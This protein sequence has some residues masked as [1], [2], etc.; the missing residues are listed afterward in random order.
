MRGVD[1]RAGGRCQLDGE[2]FLALQHV[3]IGDRHQN[4]LAGFARG[5]R[6]HLVHGGVVAARQGDAFD[7]LDRDA[8]GDGGRMV[9]RDR[10][11]GVADGLVDGCRA[12]DRHERDILDGAGAVHGGR[13]G[14]CL[15]IEEDGFAGFRIRVRQRRHPHDERVGA[16][17]DG[18]LAVRDRGEGLAAVEGDFQRA[19]VRAHGTGAGAW[20]HVEHGRRGGGGGQR[21][22]EI[23]RL[24]FPGRRAGDGADTR[25]VVVGATGAATVVL[26]RAEH[27]RGRQ[28]GVDRFAQGELEGL[29]TFVDRVVQDGDRD[30]LARLA[31]CE[32]DQPRH[33]GVVGAT[34][35][36]AVCRG[37]AHRDGLLRRIGQRHGEH[38]LSGPFIDGDGVHGL[39]VG[40]L[41]DDGRH[42]DRVRDVD[43]AGQQRGRQGEAL[44][45]LVGGVAGDRRAHQGALHPRRDRHAGRRGPGRAVV[46]RDF[47]VLRGAGGAVVDAAALGRAVRQGQA[48]RGGAVG[49]ACERD[50]EDRVASVFLDR[51]IGHRRDRRCQPGSRH[52]GRRIACA[53]G[54]G[55]VEVRGADHLDD[56][57]DPFRAVE[58]AVL[59]TGQAGAGR[60]QAVTVHRHAGQA[61]AFGLQLHDAVL[62]GQDHIALADHLADLQL[63]HGA[64]RR[65]H[66]GV[67]PD[68]H[69]HALRQAGRHI[70]RI[71][72]Q[73]L[74]ALQQAGLAGEQG[75]FQ[76]RSLGGSHGG[77]FSSTRRSRQNRANRVSLT[78]QMRQ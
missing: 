16:R 63:A 20:R 68:P 35:R 4:R 66:D 5:K 37:V 14:G 48:E 59:A 44:V 57:P 38:G 17:R 18:D 15:D 70:V 3:V 29:V 65:A 34:G 77:S 22:G 42:A 13:V 6:Q 73:A 50:G 24:A 76:G 28:A 54:R 58:R 27:V 49:A 31:R 67:A 45:G 10:V 12:G 78:H 11:G 56:P 62:R 61:I 33:R 23:Q 72:R 43:V 32:G 74:Q 30:G 39:D 53:L 21:D 47:Q 1:D 46:E 55:E 52:A 25:P 69:D 26:D 71:Q 64:V 2:G 75:R 36:C 9:Q 7:G 51:H 19:G 8:H 40:Q 60:L 41:V